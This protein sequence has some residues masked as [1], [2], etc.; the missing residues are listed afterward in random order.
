MCQQHREPAD[1]TTE[2]EVQSV[3]AANENRHPP[4]QFQELLQ[5][6]QFQ[7]EAPLSERLRPVEPP[8]RE[9]EDV[10]VDDHRLAA[11]LPHDRA[12]IHQNVFT[13][14][15]GKAHRLRTLTSPSEWW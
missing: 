1:V 3:V 11:P 12:C 10:T 13:S 8:P 2:I 9:D 4:Q 6:M 7:E 15:T 14:S 5:S